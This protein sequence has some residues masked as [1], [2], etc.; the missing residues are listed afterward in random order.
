MSKVTRILADSF[1]AA[2]AF[3]GRRANNTAAS[4]SGVVANDVL[5]Q[6]TATGYNS[7]A[8]Y[9]AVCGDVRVLAGETHSGTAAGSYITFRTTANTTTTLAEAIRITGAGVL[10]FTIAPPA[11]VTGDKYLII[12]SSG[13]VHKS[14]LGPAS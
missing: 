10:V 4:P 6:L 3:S 8:A 12:D 11:F 2:N 1:G 14:G 5:C 13:N 9:G 7:A